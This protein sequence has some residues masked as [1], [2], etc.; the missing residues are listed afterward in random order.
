[1]WPYWL[2]FLLTIPGVF[3]V[4]M[5]R[6]S[7][8]RLAWFTLLV[9]FTALI[10]WRHEV[11]GDWGSYIAHF[12]SM[13]YLSFEKVLSRGDP[14]YYLINWIVFQLGGSIY[15]VNLFCAILV[16][17][18]VNVFSRQQPLPW[19]ALL[20]A[21]PYLLVVVAMG[22]SRQAAALGLALIGLSALGNQQTRRFVIWVLL[23]ALFHKSAVLLLPL[24]ALASTKNRMWSYFWVG[25]TAVA[26]TYFLVLDSVD[27]L[28]TNYVEADYQSQGGLIRVLMNAVPAVFII[29]FRNKLFYSLPERKLWMWMAILSLI[30]VP[31]VT[32]SSTAVDRVALYFIP[33]QLFVF[34]RLPLLSKSSRDQQLWVFGITFYYALVL[35]VWLNYA[36]HAYV[37]LP[38]QN[39]LF[40]HL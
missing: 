2:M 34:A 7:N 8:Q 24:A 6:S 20:V 39:L 16:M 23:G 13:Q 36:S 1:M 12:N 19:L 27:T 32:V 10:A 9:I 3:S 21:T 33:I 40:L 25:I 22:Y 11:G 26:G 28:W 29:V 14:G 30:M 17:S 31:L 18:G 35:F 4:R 38:Y 37:W 5:V 15:W